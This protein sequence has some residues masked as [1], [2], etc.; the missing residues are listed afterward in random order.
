MLKETPFDRLMSWF[1]VHR[2]DL[3]WRR[4]RSFYSVLVSEMMLQQTQVV[5]VLGYYARF[6]N[7]FPTLEALA[8]ASLEDVYIVWSG[9]GYYR[10]ARYLWE[11]ARLLVKEGVPPKGGWESVPGLGQYTISALR[12]F[13]L[14]ECVGVLDA[15]VKR[16]LARFR[17]ISSLKEKRLW[18]VITTFVVY[19][20]RRGY[21]PRDVNEAFMELG[22][23]VCGRERR[24]YLCPFQRVCCTYLRGEDIFY[25]REKKSYTK[26]QERCIA[27]LKDD[28]KVWVVQGERWR[29][30]LWDLPLW[31]EKL[32]EGERLGGFV[33]EYGVTHHRVER[34]VEVYRVKQMAG[35]E[36]GRWVMVTSPEVALGSPARRCLEFLQD[37]VTI[38]QNLS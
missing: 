26:V 38:P 2:R 20:V 4:D 37:F 1:F 21:E 7:R 12:A 9:L 14:N 15:N 6:M 11:A 23:L 17:G 30:G 33:L 35:W 16:V 5:R 19:G 25:V 34:Q 10:R 22:A 8:Q 27:Y 32:E 24:C 29:K 28:G 31:K 18:E 3:P 13:A 36:G